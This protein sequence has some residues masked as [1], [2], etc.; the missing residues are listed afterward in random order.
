[1]NRSNNPYIPNP[2]KILK[3]TEETEDIK[4]F[5]IGFIDDKLKESFS[6][7]PGQFVMFSVLGVGEAPFCISSSPTVKDYFQCSIKKTGKV[8]QEIHKLEVGDIIGIRGPYGNGFP[9]DGLK[10]K[11]LLFVAGGIGLAP[12]RSL[13]NYCLG[14]RN[15]FKKITIFNGARTSKDLVYK[16]EYKTWEKSPDTK[17]YLTIDCQEDNWQCMVGVVPKILVEIN[18]SCENASA[19]VCGPPIMIKYTIP[20]LIKLGFCEDAL[21]TTMERQMQC[22]LGICGHCMIGGVYVCKDG[23]VFSYAQIKKFIEQ[24]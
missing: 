16:N 5:D 23:P 14:N 10:G 19:I 4:T 17:L 18:P 6:Y 2:A 8:T 7:I 24:I 9:V 12:L 3:I 1:M 11:N 21:I 15:D 20:V 13:I 22:G